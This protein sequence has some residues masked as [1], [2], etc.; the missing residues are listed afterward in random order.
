MS[1]PF[2]R[3][4]PYVLREAVNTRWAALRVGEVVSVP[5]SKR[6]QVKIGGS[7]VIIPRLS[8][9][10]PTVGEG[11]QI[12]ADENLGTLLALGAVG[13]VPSGVGPPG[14]TGPAGPAG[15][16]GAT[17]A[18]GPPGPVGPTNP[19]YAQLKAGGW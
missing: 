14:P 19:T 16:T 9:Y 17:G 13:G 10:T 15:P 3:S 2:T 1:V 18:T 7:N 6:V 4:L 12:L 8:S 5:D 11:V